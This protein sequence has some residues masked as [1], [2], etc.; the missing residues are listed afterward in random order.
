M[1]GSFAFIEFSDPSEAARGIIIFTLAV[2]KCNGRKFEGCSL[3]VQ[4]AGDNKKV[5]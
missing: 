4:R 2:E 5:D 3:V 1:K